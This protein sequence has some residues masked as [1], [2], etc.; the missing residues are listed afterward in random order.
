MSLT[1]NLLLQSEGIDP[2]DV[3]LLRHAKRQGDS[4]MS[5]Y[6]A[7]REQS[8]LFERYQATQPTKDRRYF[9][10]PFWASFVATPDRGTLFVGLFAVELAKERIAEF[11]CPLTA[12]IIA[13]KSVDL[14]RTR[15]LDSFA[16]YAGK[17][18]IDWGPGTRSWAQYADRRDKQVVE[19]R[20][21]EAELPYPGHTAFLCQLSQVEALPGGWR[22]VLANARGVYLLTC[23][24]S[25]EQYV[26]AAFAQGGFLARWTQHALISGDAIAFRSRNPEDYRASILEVA[27]SLA[28]DD[29]IMRMELRWK[30][31]LQSREM[32][33]N[34]N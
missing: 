29:D 12:R 31:K 20:R 15:A 18:L 27:G 34:R 19:L 7:W 26:G 16:A 14:Y 2:R 33:L 13:A 10:T 8:D 21:D 11:V 24:R 3:R 28:T 5:P 9:K 25:R 30:E 4:G 23:P 6:Q 1:L 17:L 32:G 22:A